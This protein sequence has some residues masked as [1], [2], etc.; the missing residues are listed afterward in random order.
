MT[1][2]LKIYKF[3]VAIKVNELQSGSLGIINSFANRKKSSKHNVWKAKRETRCFFRTGVNPIRD[4]Y[5]KK[6]QC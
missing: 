5:S 6:R 3:D 2:Q 4:I 1:D